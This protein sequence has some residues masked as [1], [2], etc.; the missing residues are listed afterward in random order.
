VLLPSIPTQAARTDA[1]QLLHV[2][3]HELVRAMPLEPSRRCSTAYHRSAYHR[4]VGQIR[5]AAIPDD[6]AHVRRLWLDYLSWGNDELAERHGFRL[7]VQEAVEHDVATIEKFQPPDGLLVLAYAGNDVF[8]TGAMKRI[9]PE[10]AEIKRMWVDPARRGNGVGRD[11][12]GRLL[13]AAQDSGYRRVRLDSPDFMGAAHALYRSTG[14]S[15]IG[16]YPES[17]IPD[18]YKRVWLFMERT[19]P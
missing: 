10:T 7:P 13:S 4:L 6:L 11:I 15:D 1:V 17:E 18:E 14:F 8:G 9:G 16:A 5:T 12:L 19:V 2:D 3:V